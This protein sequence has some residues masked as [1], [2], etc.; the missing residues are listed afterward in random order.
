MDRRLTPRVFAGRA[1]TSWRR[2]AWAALVIAV[3]LVHGTVTRELADRMT[4]I[5]PANAMPERIAV[6][7]VRT[8][9]PE[10][11]PPPPR[12][13]APAP[14]PPKR[15]APHRVARAASAVEAPASQVVADAAPPASAPEPEQT[16]A[17]AD[18][19]AS[20]AASDATAASASASA[21][22][23]EASAPAA[24]AVASA[25]PTASAAAAGA[26][27]AFEWPASTRVSYV[28]VGNYRGE[29]SGSAQVEWIRVAE[30]YQTNVDLAIGPDFAPLITRR[31]TSAGR[32]APSGLMPERYDEDTHI[33]FR[34][35]RRMSVVFESDAVI[36]ANGERR[37]PVAGAQDAASQFVQLTYLFTTRPELLKVGAAV[38]FPLAL[39]RAIDTYVYD[40]VEMQTVDSPFGPL[41]AFHLKP[42]PRPGRKPGSLSIEFWIA[43][44]LRYLPVRIRIE[45]DP[46]TF[47]ELTIAQKPEMGDAQALTSNE[48]TR[49]TP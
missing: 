33:A 46:A 45:Q 44:E 10:A 2:L 11:P 32:I 15:R 30:R 4:Q 37:D 35:H 6:A 31:M 1:A 3:V 7:Y 25:D 24:E 43:P 28:L 20:A 34:D 39:P 14:P 48:P 12:A 49:K 41:V 42:R 5:D 8:I 38:G 17:S 16:L 47:A 9:E 26:A 29:V 22:A 18:A 19:S 40:V 21:P 23:A 13:A 36:L 27:A